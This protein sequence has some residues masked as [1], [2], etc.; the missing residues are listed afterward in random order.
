M[1]DS[2][3]ITMCHSFISVGSFMN[4]YQTE[5]LIVVSFS[6]RKTEVAMAS[7]FTT[8]EKTIIWTTAALTHG[9]VKSNGF[10]LSPAIFTSMPGQ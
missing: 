7:L 2:M 8:P 5:V 9:R 10:L 6:C 1:I 3:I 4:S